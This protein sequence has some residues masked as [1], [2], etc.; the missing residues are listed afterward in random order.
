VQRGFNALILL[1][2]LAG[3]ASGETATNYDIIPRLSQA[4]GNVTVTGAGRL[5]M[6]QHQFYEPQYSV[7]ERHDDNS[8]TPFPNKELNERT[9]S[10]DLKLDSVLGIRTDANG[11]V[12]MLDDGMRSGV[13]PKLVGWHVHIKPGS[14]HTGGEDQRS[15]ST[16]FNFIRLARL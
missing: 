11:V 13:T 4:P 16:N 1:V 7:V 2:A 14:F 9:G 8:L 6:S 3:H 15:E 12:W 10:S 5:I